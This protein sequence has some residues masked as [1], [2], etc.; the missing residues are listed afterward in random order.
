MEEADRGE[1][2]A[3]RLTG[4]WRIALSPGGASG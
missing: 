2:P 4:L 1:I 3:M